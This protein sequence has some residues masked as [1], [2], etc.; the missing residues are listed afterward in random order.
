MRR[1][2]AVGLVALVACRGGT[3]AA[4]LHGVE[5]VCEEVISHAD[6]SGCELVSG[7][8]VEVRV[9][10][11][12]ELPE[13]WINDERAEPIAARAVEGGWRLT[14]RPSEGSAQIIVRRA[15][16]SPAEWRLPL[17]WRAE[18]TFDNTLGETYAAER[19][20]DC[21]ALAPVEFSAACAAGRWLRALTVARTGIECS[22]RDGDMAAVDRW[23]TDIERV[24]YGDDIRGL[25]RDELLISTLAERGVLYAIADTLERALAR[26]VRLGTTISHSELLMRR[27]ALL[28]DL[29]DLAGAVDAA[30][31]ALDPVAH[32]YMD[33]CDR[34]TQR[35]AIAW[36]LL[37]AASRTRE[38]VRLD[39]A[40]GEL[41]TALALAE[42]YKCSPSVAYLN[43]AWV[44]LLA[45][46]PQTAARWL[47]EAEPL[48]MKSGGWELAELNMLRARTL[49][50]MGDLVGA[51][52]AI[53]RVGAELATTDLV[54]TRAEL[55]EAEG[56]L[57]RAEE[58]L[59][60]EH[61]R[62]LER[63]GDVG[64]EQGVSRSVYDR[65]IATQ[66]LVRLMIVRGDGAAALAVARE[67]AAPEARLLAARHA[68]SGS[69]VDAE[70]RAY[71]G[72]RD[73]CEQ[74]LVKHWERSGP[75]REALCAEARREAALLERR[76]IGDGIAVDMV[77]L[78]LQRPAAGEV[79]LLYFP[80]TR[81]RV[82]GFAATAH[83]VFTAEIAAA[84]IP[85]AERGEL[86]EEALAAA[87]EAL[88]EPFAL[89][90]DGARHVRVLPSFGRQSLPF[91]ALPW[92]GQPLLIHADVETSLDL[93]ARRELVEE[94]SSVLVLGDPQGNL[95]D[96][97]VEA[98][99]VAATLREGGAAVHSLVGKFEVTGPV[100]RAMLPEVEHLHYAGHSEHGGEFGWAGALRLSEGTALSIP[101]ILTLRRVP[102]TVSLL[103][104]TSGVVEEDPRNQSVALATAFL[105]AGSRA[106]IATTSLLPAA[107]APAIAAAL[108]ADAGEAAAFDLATAYRSA[109]LR[110]LREQ[111]SPG[112]WQSLRLWV[113]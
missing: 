70:R 91:H 16:P 26:S 107:E 93:P 50:A 76:V 62:N 49:I 14:L 53:N 41:H 106:V 75:G 8:D 43:L 97:R 6:G 2:V 47:D 29:G 85:S 81:E 94:G 35:V 74:R 38:A 22:I 34:V 12:G 28:G 13:V 1:A 21:K 60:G 83:A 48:A 3:E 46:A 36:T 100:L 4:P 89:A 73:T 103:S 5:F 63:I 42:Q 65:L 72:W 105:I 79:F 59:A 56:D 95:A 64:H 31:A 99:A 104:C 15:S 33:D 66:A 88:L 18:Q 20:R 55:A 68:R 67:A 44:G 86:D 87:S 78:S 58:L 11:P 98:E 54:M 37:Q 57:L 90:I 102:A 17:V 84:E 7:P 108:Y 71:L 19:W 77:G 32:P 52:G 111:V 69:D 96:A 39:E 82:L 24:P 23:L 51:R 112:T 27:S 109:M 110:A 40:E 25:R 101:D 10:V 92:R 80:L 45:G 30:E 61:R 113:P 9:W